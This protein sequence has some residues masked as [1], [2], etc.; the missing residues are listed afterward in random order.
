MPTSSVRCIGSLSSTG[1]VIVGAA[2]A[3]PKS[4]C[5]SV[6]FARLTE[7]VTISTVATAQLGTCCTSNAHAPVAP[8][9][10]APATPPVPAPPAPA[11]PVPAPPSPAEAAP[12][13]PFDP[14]LPPLPPP[15]PPP[16][17]PAPASDLAA[18]PEHA[19]PQAANT[20]ARIATGVVIGS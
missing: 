6:G 18:P 17:P 2:P 20:I 9:D 19:T 1:A 12:L 15:L 16:P 13:P 3:G 8:P 11:E 4:M 5:A 14:L 10:P 7:N